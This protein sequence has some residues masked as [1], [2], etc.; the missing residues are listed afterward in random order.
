MELL[1]IITPPHMWGFGIG[2]SYL[3]VFTALLFKEIS[4]DSLKDNRT[5]TGKSIHDS[6]S[7]ISTSWLPMK[8]E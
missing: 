6:V 4:F 1:M 5:T 3:F 7:D 8:F 2:N